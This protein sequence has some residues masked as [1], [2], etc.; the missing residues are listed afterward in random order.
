VLRAVGF[1][2]TFYGPVS[3]RAFAG[4]AA[5][6]PATFRF[7]VKAPS[8]LTD[9]Y[10]RANGGR[11]TDR[12]PRFLDVALAADQ[13]VTPCVAGLREKLGMLVFQFP[14]LGGRA[15]RLA[16][17]FVERLSAFLNALRRE[18]HRH[19]PIAVEVRDPELLGEPL[20]RALN[21]AGA[22]FCFSVHARMPSFERQRQAMAGLA[23]GALVARWNLHAGFQY[24]QA[25]ARYAPFDRLVD[26]D[27]ATRTA[28]AEAV[29]STL[30]LGKPAIVIANNK[31]EGSAPLSAIK[32]A[33]AIVERQAKRE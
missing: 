7:L 21:E 2:R 13:V 18:A 26:E 1:D 3:E 32:L 20:A 25:K 16:D 15:A 27:P 28:I 5:Q 14:P 9:A 17:R 6:V 10:L 8:A 19:V 11:A 33:A 12:N 30:R 24:E 4:H 31:A 29:V 22:R 23:P